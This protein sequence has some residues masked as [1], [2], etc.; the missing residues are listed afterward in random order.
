MLPYKYSF[1]F[2]RISD[3]VRWNEKRFD[4]DGGTEVKPSTIVNDEQWYQMDQ[5]GR[6]SDQMGTPAVLLC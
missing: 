1:S 3:V 4:E 6:E 5:S 2:P